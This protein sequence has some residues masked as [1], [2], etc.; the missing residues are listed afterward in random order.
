VIYNPNTIRQHNCFIAKID[1]IL[2]EVFKLNV[3]PEDIKKRT[4]VYS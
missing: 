4:K 1:W 3:H 2:Q